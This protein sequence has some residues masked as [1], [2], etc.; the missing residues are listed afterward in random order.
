MAMCQLPSNPDDLMQ[1]LERANIMHLLGTIRR[2]I[3]EKI[4]EKFRRVETNIHEYNR[5]GKQQDHKV[6]RMR[7]E[8]S[9]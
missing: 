3:R 2:K 1:V 6:N 7:G 9:S 4:L 8:D 5:G